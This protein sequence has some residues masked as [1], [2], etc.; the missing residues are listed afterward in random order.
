MVSKAR[1]IIIDQK[2]KTP[3]CLRHTAHGNKNATSKSKIINKIAT[4]SN[5]K[6]KNI[7][8]KTCV[9]RKNRKSTNENVKNIKKDI[10]INKNWCEKYGVSV[11]KDFIVTRP[12]ASTGIKNTT[13]NQST[14]KKRGF[15]I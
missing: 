1:K 5:K 8:T 11:V 3:I 10:P 13:S 7:V 12:A 15:I 14:C 9:L 4:K 2:P 6:N